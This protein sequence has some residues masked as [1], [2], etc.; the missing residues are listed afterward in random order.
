MST[1]PLLVQAMKPFDSN[2]SA[3]VQ[4]K[5]GCLRNR[6]KDGQSVFMLIWSGWKATHSFA[7]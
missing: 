1:N 5:A 2:T 4:K 7:T 3:L 6:Q